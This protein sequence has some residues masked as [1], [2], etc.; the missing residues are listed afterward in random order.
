MLPEL[1]R[2]KPI[3][4]AL[5]LIS[6]FFLPCISAIETGKPHDTVQ[7]LTGENFEEAVNDPANG[8]WFLKFYAPWCGHCKKLEPIMNE[9]APKLAG[10]MA[11]GKIDCTT[12][13]TVCGKYGID[14]FP[15]LNVYRDGE[16]LNYPARREAD[17]IIEF[18]EKMSAQAVTLVNAFEEAFEKVVSQNPNGVGFIAYDG[19]AFAAVDKDEITAEDLLSST[20]TLQIYGQVARKMQAFGHFGLLGPGISE[21][22]LDKFGL[23]KDKSAFMRLEDNVE[24]RLYDGEMNTADFTDFVQEQNIP[25]VTNLDSHNFYT[26]GRKGKP[27]VISV[28][29]PDDKE[30]TPKV[31]H[32]LRNYALTG[33]TDITSKYIFSYLN[34]VRWKNFLKQFSVN[35]VPDIFVLDVPERVYWKDPSIESIGDFVSSVAEGK[36]ESK[37]QSNSGGLGVLDTI[38]KFLLKTMPYSVIIVFVIFAGIIF[39]IISLDDDEK[40]I[41]DRTKVKSSVVTEKNEIT[42]TEKDETSKKDD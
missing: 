5:T 17:S 30:V 4:A 34:G 19:S 13:K 2:R 35:D 23:T 1:M 38:H 9:I 25:I 31:L 15:T 33:P 40:E 6:S 16:V 26:V 32:E 14:R 36:I 41:E 20:T 11:I 28:I 21:K 39:L 10:K 7:I 12:E 22:E 8:L 24:T 18:G 27:L 37:I 3:W 42:K 29:D